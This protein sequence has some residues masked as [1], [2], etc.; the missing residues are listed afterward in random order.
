[1]W[2]KCRKIAE[3]L[4]DCSIAKCVCNVVCSSYIIYSTTYYY[5]HMYVRYN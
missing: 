5:T 2:K 3:S 1:M 4:T